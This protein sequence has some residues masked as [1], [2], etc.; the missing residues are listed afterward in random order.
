MTAKGGVMRAQ[1][2]QLNFPQQPQELPAPAPTG[3]GKS[4]KHWIVAAFAFVAALA[5]VLG[6]LWGYDRWEGGKAAERFD[7]KARA[8]A[9]ELEASARLSSDLTSRD[10]L[11]KATVAN[12][13]LDALEP[14]ALEST[15]AIAAFQTTVEKWLNSGYFIVKTGDENGLD[16][17]DE[18]L[19]N[20]IVTYDP[21]AVPKSKKTVETLKDLEDGSQE[22]ATQG[23]EATQAVE[24]LEE[25][26]TNAPTE[27][28]LAEEEAAEGG[29][30]NDP[31]E[32]IP[33]VEG[34][35]PCA[36]E[37]LPRGAQQITTYG[38]IG[39]V[40]ETPSGNIHC[41]IANATS[42]VDGL[43]WCAVNSW[44]PS[45]MPNYD[46]MSGGKITV[47]LSANG[48][49]ADL[50]QLGGVPFE[51]PSVETMQYGN[52]YYWEDFVLASE[53]SGLTV[54]SLNTGHGAFF[55]KGGFYPF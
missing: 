3:Q 17:G 45:M 14:A 12:L 53:D 50:G 15:E 2:A 11:A 22:L 24:T 7:A 31:H 55:N 39:A 44:E 16:A 54:W 51:T 41:Y 9:A 25:E 19:S 30:E 49:P 26:L 37:G 8:M 33:P 1:E 38:D 21:A 47:A 40:S 32:C 52:V 4:K 23:K 27:T 13:E 10:E 42:E 36:G 34:A 28:V 43:L 29:E 35:Y 18:A 20:V 5:V 48:G 6:G 46:S